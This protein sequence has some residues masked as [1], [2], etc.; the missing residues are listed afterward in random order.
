MKPSGPTA[1]P[2][3]TQTVK[4]TVAGINFATDVF[5][6]PAGPIGVAFG[7]EYRKEESL[8]TQDPLSA[9]GALFFNA[10]GTRGGEYNVKEPTAKSGSR[11]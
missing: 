6:L 7:A 10:I 9:S 3:P 8:F 1:S 4:Q 5:D 11:S 2:R